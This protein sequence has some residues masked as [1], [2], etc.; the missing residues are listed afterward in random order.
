MTFR[1]LRVTIRHFMA[2]LTVQGIREL[3]KSIIASH[4]GGIR[5]SQLVSQISTANPETPQNTIHGTVWNLDALF[6]SSITKPSRGLFKPARALHVP[7]AQLS[8]TQARQSQE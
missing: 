2:K 3:A 8:F 7:R 5:Y 4:P 6:P 1:S